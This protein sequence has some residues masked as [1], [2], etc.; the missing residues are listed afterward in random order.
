[1][2][3]YTEVETNFAART[4][5]E[6]DPQALLGIV[7]TVVKATTRE[8][9]LLLAKNAKSVARTTTLN[10]SV[11]VVLIIM[12]QVDTGPSKKEREK[13]SMR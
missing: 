3:Q 9:V 7:S 8:I 12:N 4:K 1:M 11:K 2:I 10:Q 13:G 5:A 6:A